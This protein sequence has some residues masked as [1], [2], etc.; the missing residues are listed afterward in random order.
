MMETKKPKPM[1]VLCPNALS[2]PLFHFTIK[3]EK[4]HDLDFLSL[5]GFQK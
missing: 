4:F 2:M 1:L 3:G 5:N